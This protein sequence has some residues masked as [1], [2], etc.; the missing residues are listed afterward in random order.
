MK[1]EKG[2][3][4][5]LVVFAI[6]LA[7]QGVSAS[8]T[9][10][11]LF[12]DNG[13]IAV[14]GY[15]GNTQSYA[16]GSMKNPNVLLKICATDAG[17]LMNKF[18]GIFYKVGDV[19]KE[20]DVLPAKITSLDGS[21]CATI[22][23]DFSM[24]KARYPGIPAIGIADEPTLAAPNYVQLTT[25]DGY[26]KG[27]YTVEFTNDS[28]TVSVNIT[29]AFTETNSEITLSKPYIIIGIVNS[30]GG[31][32]N[33][34]LVQLGQMVTLTK[35]AGDFNFSINSIIISGSGGVAPV[36]PTP[37]PAAAVGG[38]GAGLGFICVFK[39]SFDKI[40]PEHPAKISIDN[41][42]TY[43]RQLDI[44]TANVVSDIS[45]T[46]FGHT[47][48]DMEPQWGKTLQYI[49]FETN[50]NQKD[51]S[52]IKVIFKVPKTWISEN[53]VHEGGG[54]KLNRFTDRWERLPTYKIDE[55]SDFVYYEAYSKG[56]SYFA[57]TGESIKMIVPFCGDGRCVETESFITC[58]QDC[59][60]PQLMPSIAAFIPKLSMLWILAAVILTI[61]LGSGIGH[62][63][64][65]RA[66]PKKVKVVQEEIPEL[67]EIALPEAGGM[68]EVPSVPM[69]LPTFSTQVK[70]RVLKPHVP[71]PIIE[72][73]LPTEPLKVPQFIPKTAAD[74]KNL[75]KRIARLHKK[76]ERAK[77]SINEVL[78]LNG[79][80]AAA[81][82]RHARKYI[83]PKPTNVKL[84]YIRKMRTE[85]KF[86]E[87]ELEGK[88][89]PAK[90]PLPK[91]VFR[92]N[93]KIG[94]AQVKKLASSLKKN[95]ADVTETYEQ[96]KKG[97]K[98]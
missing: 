49:A 74:Y 54:V 62:Y 66:I 55:D 30:T 87:R 50:L 7:V 29:H 39:N 88:V 73:T 17:D 65:G 41:N 25:A 40:I 9:S 37:T 2:M 80:L 16:D 28:T 26:M 43:L 75:P 94:P 85:V 53:A 47:D 5:S 45:I 19:S 57:I 46:I 63:F 84:P 38:G 71:E 10:T 42:C 92:I 95:I 90:V 34:T 36:P 13:S 59:P 69:E 51:T 12:Y 64:K 6:L 44:S 91:P 86:A 11:Q 97:V 1:F 31:I 58:P 79:T 20:I 24:F 78:K 76:V 23:T 15:D 81:A 22:D 96:L 82:A 4:I 32:V 93:H 98:K 61:I 27:N 14:I 33:S 67:P 89:K 48:F 18:I 72:P 35:P 77:T 83:E 8:I 3:K 56:L 21:N 68:P 52:V 60:T 70:P